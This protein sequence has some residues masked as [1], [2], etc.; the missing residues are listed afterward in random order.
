MAQHKPIKIC[1]RVIEFS[2]EGKSSCQIASLLLIG[3][4]T[5]NN[6]IVK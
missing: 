2:K 1:E 3:K 6:I 4:S 5:V